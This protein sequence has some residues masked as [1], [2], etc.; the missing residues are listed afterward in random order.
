MENTKSDIEVVFNN[1]DIGG[2]EY[3]LLIPKEYRKSLMFDCSGEQSISIL[4][5]LPSI[6]QGTVIVVDTIRKVDGLI[7]VFC[8][9]EIISKIYLSLLIHLPKLR[10]KECIFI[11]SNKFIVTNCLDE[12]NLSVEYAH[13]GPNGE[14]DYPHSFILSHLDDED[15]EE[16]RN[17]FDEN[18]DY[19]RIVRPNGEDDSDDDQDL[20]YFQQN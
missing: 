5:K 4:S 6:L 13:K 9:K 7:I 15:I 2:N 14:T 8:D 3:T 16:M 20:R 19:I 10:I 17:E 12:N 11:E 18:N 1:Y